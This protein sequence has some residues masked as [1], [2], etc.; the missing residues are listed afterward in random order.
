MPRKPV[1]HREGPA[2]TAGR[3][4]VPWTG[5]WQ[6]IDAPRKERDILEEE[7]LVKD[8]IRQLF[9]RYGVLFRDLLA[10]EL[11][12][13]QWRSIFRSLRL[14]ELSGEILSGYFFEGISGP[15]F[16]SHEAFRMLQEP[17]P[18][19]AVFWINATDPASLCGL[20][21]ESLRGFPPRVA[22]T[23][24]VYHGSRLVM[25]SRRMGKGLDIFVEPDDARLADYFVLFKDLLARE[26]QPLQRIVVE[27]IN[28]CARSFAAPLPRR[29]RAVRV[30]FRAERAGAVE[31]VLIGN[32]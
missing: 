21:L 12:P 28:G 1:S 24:L 30:P 31:G 15:Q 9:K 4:P 18:Q 25:I 10:N 11:P 19:D 5:N 8:R 20:G 3:S 32:R 16:I 23:Y 22:S 13:L 14:M 29:C 17:L 27:T 26:F 6:R 2:L 7:E